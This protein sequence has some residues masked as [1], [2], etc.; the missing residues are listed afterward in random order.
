MGYHFG[1]RGHASF[2]LIEVEHDHIPSNL[3]YFPLIQPQQI[4]L[5]FNRLTTF[6]FMPILV[7]SLLVLYYLVDEFVLFNL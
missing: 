4:I 3:E 5:P 7:L 2:Y 1:A 6:P